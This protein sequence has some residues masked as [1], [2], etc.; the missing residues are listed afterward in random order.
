MKF[1]WSPLETELRHWR[2][3]GLTL[4]I[5]WRDDDAVA[6]TPALHRLTALAETSGIAVHIAVIPDLVTPTLAPVVAAH[7]KLVPMVHGWRHESH[8]PEGSKKAEFGHPRPTG[9]GELHAG[10]TRLSGLFGPRLLPVFV[11]PWNRIDGAYLPALADAGYRAVSTFRPRRTAQAAEGLW[12]INTHL[13]PIFWKGHRSLMDPEHLIA[14][15]VT[16][17]QDRRRGHVDTDEPYGL[18]TH[19]LVHD[20]AIWDF[21]HAY[22]A[23]ML[24]GGARPAAPLVPKGIPS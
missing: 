14:D 23:H 5:W 8:A 3:E 4:P 6:D 1:D 16:D 15:L 18:L 22:L 24:E 7:E 20:T 19:H 9:V 21:T 2:R 10:I 11:P 12:Q 17:L 13:D